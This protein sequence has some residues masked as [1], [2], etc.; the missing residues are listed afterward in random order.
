[1]LEWRWRGVRYRISLLF[2]ALLTALLLIQP[3]GTAVTC[4]LASLAHECGHLL[5]MMVCRVP[6]ECCVLGAFGM[7]LEVGEHR[8]DY[9]EN[10][11]VSLAGPLVNAMLAMLFW[12]LGQPTV[13]AIHLLLCLF[14]L[15][16]VKGLDGGEILRCLLCMRWEPTRVERGLDILSLA[17]IGLLGLFS[18]VLWNFRVGTGTLPI[19][20]VYLLIAYVAEHEK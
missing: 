5:L 1:M 8:A 4:V 9:R 20:T 7:R 15:L 3:D 10:I 6:P 14:N 13:A 12:R 2:P 17:L 18:C 19:V 16:P 11:L